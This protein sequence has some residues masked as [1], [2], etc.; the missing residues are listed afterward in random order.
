MLT[1]R[2]LSEAEYGGIDT[3]VGLPDPP[4]VTVICAHDVYHCGAPVTCRPIC[5]IFT[6]YCGDA[7]SV[8]NEERIRAKEDVR[9]RWARSSGAWS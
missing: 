6:R 3:F 2:P 9:R 5:S 7:V 8:C 1:V 4:P